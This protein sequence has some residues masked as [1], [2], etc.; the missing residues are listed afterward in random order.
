[1]INRIEYV[2]MF[3]TLNKLLNDL[4]M[5]ILRCHNQSCFAADRGTE[6]RVSAKRQQ[7]L[8]LESSRIVELRVPC[9]ST[10]CLFNVGRTY[11]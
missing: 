7:E 8:N 1:M 5:S 11:I 4:M 6:I 10:Q 3:D 9:S 2:C